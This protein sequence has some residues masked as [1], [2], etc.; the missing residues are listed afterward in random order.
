MK[1]NYFKHSWNFVVKVRSG[2]HEPQS[3]IIGGHFIMKGCYNAFCCLFVWSF[4]SH[5]RIFHWYGN[6]SIIGEGFR[7]LIYTLQSWPLSGEGS[8]AYCNTGHPFIMVISED[9]WHSHLLPTVQQWKCRYL[10]LQV[11][12]VAAGIQTPNVPLAG[13]TL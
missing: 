10:F 8:L 11:R 4:M 3:F 13:Q 7:I 2:E 12:S 5:S 1:T 6:V 9:P